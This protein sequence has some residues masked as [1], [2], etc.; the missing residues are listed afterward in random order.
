[1]LQQMPF[2]VEVVYYTIAR[3]IRSLRSDL[4]DI[5]K[6]FSIRASIEQGHD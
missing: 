5:T 3:A 1:M 4:V 6:A 2:A